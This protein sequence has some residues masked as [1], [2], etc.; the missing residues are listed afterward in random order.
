VAVT[1]AVVASRSTPTDIDPPVVRVL[2]GGEPMSV[3]QVRARAHNVNAEGLASLAPRLQPAR[4]TD[5]AVPTPV[6]A[7]PV[8]VLRP[9]G[10]VTATIVYFHGGGWIVGD[11]DTHLAQARRLCV[12]ASAVVVSVD[13][14]V[15][16]EHRFPAAFDDAVAA[17][18]WV[19]SHPDTFGGDRPLVVA[20]DGSGAQLAA[21]VAIAR[22]DAGQSLAAQIL[23]HPV[24]DVAGRYADDEINASYM[25]RW[26]GKK[27]STLTLEALAQFAQLYVDAESAAD[28]R[29]SPKRAASLAGVAPAVIHTSTLD[30]LRT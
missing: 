3:A 1:D 18:E 28:W 16:P 21:S 14:R 20:G 6:G 9:A 25:S 2:A 26:S 7:L 24:T 30:V 8:R 12:L 13:Y 15:A 19:A 5:E 17:T 29:V 23:L 22:R 10:P 4:E 11:L 27:R